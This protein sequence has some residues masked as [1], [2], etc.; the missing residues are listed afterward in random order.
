MMLDPSF[1]VFDY[2]LGA[3]GLPRL[4]WIFDINQAVPS[5]ILTDVWQWSPFVFLI[6]LAGIRSI[7]PELFDS[8]SVDGANYVQTFRRI[9]WPHIQPFLAIAVLFR[10]TDALKEVDKVLN[11]TRGGPAFGTATLH[12]MAWFEAFMTYSLSTGVTIALILLVI[13]NVVTTVQFRLLQRTMR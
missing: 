11:L 12:Y 4:D 5:L 7:P 2:L 3:I 10:L 6:L 13:I 8:A 9:I 1:G